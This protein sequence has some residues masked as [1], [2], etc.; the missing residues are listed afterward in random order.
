MIIL[1]SCAFCNYNYFGIS[2]F[3]LLPHVDDNA[4]NNFYI[5]LECKRQKYAD[6]N[7]KALLYYTGK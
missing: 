1:F 5:F 2:I 3:D 4:I 6:K 7:G